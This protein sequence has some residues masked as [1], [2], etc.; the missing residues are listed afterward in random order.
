MLIPVQWRKKKENVINPAKAKSACT[1]GHL[2][3]GR[4]KKKQHCQ[5]C[6]G[7]FSFLLSSPITPLGKPKHAP[8]ESRIL[9]VQF[10]AVRAL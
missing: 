5:A 2:P 9:L 4:V 10:N 6:S 1:E 7:F 3:G 8:E